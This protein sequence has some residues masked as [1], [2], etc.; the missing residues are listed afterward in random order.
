[1]DDINQL[2]RR[3]NQAPALE[4]AAVSIRQSHL[5][6]VQNKQM[7]DAGMLESWPVLTA[8]QYSTLQRPLSSVFLY[9]RLCF[10]TFLL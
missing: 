2:E 4:P 1:M 7:W 5:N 9:L 3:L 10:P 6:K 8:V